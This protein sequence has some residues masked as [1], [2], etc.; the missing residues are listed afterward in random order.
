MCSEFSRGVISIFEHVVS[1]VHGCLFGVLETTLKKLIKQCE[2]NLD[3]LCYVRKKNTK[4]IRL[5]TL[6]IH[7]AWRN[8]NLLYNLA[9]FGPMCHQITQVLF[10]YEINSSTKTEV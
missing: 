6:E 4:A 7:G 3:G 1:V 2:K 9:D 5:E 10:Q 8:Q